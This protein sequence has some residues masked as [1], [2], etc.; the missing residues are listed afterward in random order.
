MLYK[1]KLNIT[2]LFSILCLGLQA[3]SRTQ[4]D[5]G[6]A[7]K[8]TINNVCLC[9]TT[10]ED[11]RKIDNELKEVPV[12]EMDLCSGGLTTDSRF[13]NGKGFYSKKFPG[14]IFQKDDDKDYISKIRLTKEFDGQLPDGFSINMRNLK[15]KDVI[16]KYPSFNTWQSRGCSDYW[17]LTNDTLSFFVKIDKQKTPQYPVDEAYYGN[18][19]IE[20][21]DFAVS[22]YGILENAG[23][24]YKKIF[25]D[26]VFFIDSLNVT[27]IELQAYQ[28]NDI[29]VVTVYGD[30]AA[31]KLLGTQGA[32]GAVYI[33]TKVF[34]RKKYWQFF[35]NKSKAYEAAVPDLQIEKE[36]VYILNGKVLTA[37]FEGDLS[38]ISNETF[39]SL[40]VIGK[41]ILEKEFETKNKQTGVIIKAVVTKKK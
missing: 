2:V 5:T 9:Q 39:I 40:E 32:D 13:V 7:V 19:L 17:N 33:E 15:A 8:L 18:Q 1:I 21:I 34:A 31:V 12:E 41:D 14:I 28:S 29:A 22:C 38:L 36:V 16:K 4:I 20:G 11:L 37:N 3:Q 30:T 35:S 10:V 24:R 25:N 6:L 27:Q 26:P 23:H